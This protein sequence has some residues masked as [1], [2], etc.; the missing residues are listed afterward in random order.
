MQ[1]ALDICRQGIEQGQTPFGASLVLNGRVLAAAHNQVHK[2][3]DPSAHAEVLCL[4]QAAAAVGDVHLEGA[5][6]YSTTEPCPMCFA[7]AHW[8][9]VR[10]IVYGARIEDAARFGFNEMPVSNATLK[11]LAGIS[12]ELLPDFRRDDALALFHHWQERGG[13]TY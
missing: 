6:L 11:E 5:T 2:L 7:C 10:R 4:R 9:R 12:V 1:V 3:H 8:S 13:E